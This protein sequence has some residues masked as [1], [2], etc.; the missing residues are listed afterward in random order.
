MVAPGGGQRGLV[1][2]LGAH[3]P[4]Q[5]DLAGEGQ[6]LHIAFL[7]AAG[8]WQ[9][10]VAGLISAAQ[11]QRVAAA[12]E[13]RYQDQ[14]T[15]HGT[16]QCGVQHGQRLGT[17]QV[18][19]RFMLGR[20]QRGSVDAQPLGHRLVDLGQRRRQR[21]A[22]DGW[23]GGASV[24]QAMLQRA[25]GDLQIAL[26]AHPTLF[27]TVVVQLTTGAEVI[28]QIGM[29]AGVGHEGGQR[30]AAADQYPGG[31]VAQDHLLRAGRAGDAAL[32][33]HHRVVAGLG[34]AQRGGGDA[35]VQAVGEGQG[36]GHQAEGGEGRAGQGPLQRAAC[37]DRH[38]HAVL[39]PVGQRALALGQAA[40]AGRHP[41]VLGQDLGP[42]Q[43]QVRQVA[44]GG[45]NAV[46]GG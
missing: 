20:N 13:G 46:L 36:G 9:R 14:L 24:L 39:V 27:P 42:P 21:K 11:Q 33:C 32:G 28:D 31:A 38:R 30:R 3:A 44:A 34:L 43:P 22:G 5:V 19:N 23:G 29:P 18:A 41:A 10:P 2:Q 25:C 15:R 40:Q 45:E 12:A 26:V 35:G 7:A 16:A 37:L 1:A 17:A 4:L 8:L 6:Q